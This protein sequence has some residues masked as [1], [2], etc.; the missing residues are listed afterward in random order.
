[1]TEDFKAAVAAANGSDIGED[2][3]FASVVKEGIEASLPPGAIAA[4]FQTLIDEP[5]R[6]KQTG[7]IGLAISGPD[8]EVKVLGIGIQV[9][10]LA[11]IDYTKGTF[12]ADFKIYLTNVTPKGELRQPL[13]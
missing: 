6:V 13:S 9:E 10:K 8:V 11:D 4:F 12:V 3:V 1:M 2:T 7:E 5:D